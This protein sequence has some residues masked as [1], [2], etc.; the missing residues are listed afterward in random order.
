MSPKLKTFLIICAKHAVGAVIG[1]ATLAT[2]LPKTFNAHDLLAFAYSTL[3]FIAA[4]EGKVWI[5]KLLAWVNS[6]TPGE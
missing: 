1:N 3:G 2:L 5:P 4:A 6:P